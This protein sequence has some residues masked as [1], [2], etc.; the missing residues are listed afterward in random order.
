MS[1]VKTYDEL[2]RENQELTM[3]LEEATDTITAI[4]TGQVDALVVNDGDQ[5][6][7]LYTLKTADQTY[8]VFI[9]KMNEGAVTLNEEGIILYSNSMFATMVDAPLSKVVG[10][11]FENFVAESATAAYKHL[12]N[13][14]WKQDSKTE[15]AIKKNNILIPC[16]LSVNT[17]QLDEGPS[18][19]IIVTD[20]TFQKNVQH[21]LKENNRRLEEINGEL[22]ASNY[23]LQQFA[24]VASH[25]LQEPLR[26]ILIFSTMLKNKHEAELPVES[27]KH[28]EKIITSSHRMRTMISDILNYSRL[29]TEAGNFEQVNLKE[30]I[31]EVLEDYEILVNEKNV[32]VKI[33]EFPLIEANRAQIKQVFQ[34]LIS[35]S[36]KFSKQDKPPVI[37]IAWEANHELQTASADHNAV[38]N[39]VISDNGIGFDKAYQERIFSLF[40]RLNTKEKYEGSGIGLAIT[41]KILDK[42][43]GTISVESKEGEGARF[44]ICLPVR[45]ERRTSPEISF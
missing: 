32:K 15:L 37:E 23:D 43:N 29:S 3:R 9:E 26:K 18:L 45:Q 7:Q 28:L 33:D 5:G 35:N 40:E 36:I 21:L 16:Q 17:L 6:L 30:I 25:D 11:P 41:K 24:S 10:S 44:T 1:I 12:F 34:N 39:I 38:C 22:E 19:S 2:I 4:R 27:Q 31:N 20:L 13:D 14:G 42:H 8:R